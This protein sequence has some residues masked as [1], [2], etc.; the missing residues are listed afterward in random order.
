MSGWTGQN[1]RDNV[2]Q[3]SDNS[4]PLQQEYDI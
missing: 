3:D 1:N 4:H 2:W